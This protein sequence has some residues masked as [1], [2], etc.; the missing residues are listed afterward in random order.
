MSEADPKPKLGPDEFLWEE[1]E[2]PE[3]KHDIVVFKGPKHHLEGWI[4][5]DSATVW[6]A[7]TS[8]GDRAEFDSEED[9]RAFLTLLINTKGGM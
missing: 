3:G 1:V 6:I 9:A 5:Q 8:T 7:R 2:T 4:L